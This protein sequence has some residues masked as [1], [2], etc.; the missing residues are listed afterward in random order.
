MSKITND[1]L[2][3]SCY[4]PTHMATVDIKGLMVWFDIAVIE[5]IC[6]AVDR[7]CCSTQRRPCIPHYWTSDKTTNVESWTAGS[8][9]I[10]S[11]WSM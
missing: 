10:T 11:H 7:H 5:L 8:E 3:R 6:S 4:S 2:T 1:G 9:S